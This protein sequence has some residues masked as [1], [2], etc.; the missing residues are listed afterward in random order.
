MKPTLAIVL[1]AGLLLASCAPAP[2]PPLPT[3]TRVPPRP[4]LEPVDLSAPMQVGASMPYMD[5]A[6]L[7]A[8][9]SGP[10][11]MG[12]GGSDDLERTVT[13]SAFWIYATEVTEGQYAL[14][15]AQGQ[16]TPPDPVSNLGY[17]DFASQNQPAVGVTYAQASAYCSYVN[18]DLPSEAQ[19][20]KAARGPDGN[21][22]PWGKAD[23]SCDL[24]NFNN[25]TRAATDVGKYARGR[26]YYGAFDMEGN[27][28][29]WTADWYDALYYRAAP[30][31]DPPGPAAGRARVIRSSGYRS[32]A[33]L[34]PAY[35]RSFA[36]PGEHRRDLG[37][38][39]VVT[40]PTYFAPFCRTV[41]VVTAAELPRLAVECPEISIQVQTSSCRYGGGAIVTFNDD[42][43][44]DPNASFG[45]ISGC[46]LTSGTPGS[47]PIQF[48]CS[49]ASTAVMT[50][51]CIYTGIGA[52]ACAAHYRLDAAT[53][54]CEWDASDTAGLDCPVGNYYDPVKH[55]C[56]ALSGSGAD[57]PACPVGT[58]FTEDSPDHFVCLPGVNA[59][60]V[61]AQTAAINPPDCPG[62]CQLNEDACN[63]RGL[64]FCSTTCSCLSVGVKCPTH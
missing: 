61:P 43:S 59:L 22:Y 9:P 55:C 46:K 57:Y 50:S 40:D 64:V 56:S 17:G 37:F 38:R 24:L 18:G 39:C 62:V 48:S 23:P 54:L 10:F 8:V 58:V 27:V 12:H 5:G 49:S 51:S 36:S 25:C 13:L 63:E 32:N 35:V 28:F 29:E 15:V 11:V 6:L 21:V 19:W 7:V 41:S 20:E 2:A 14:C 4:T 45:G 52:S 1:A 44:R 47:Y 3:P 42:H 34:L 16:C 31:Q 33:A 30:D 60:A 53:G 26:S